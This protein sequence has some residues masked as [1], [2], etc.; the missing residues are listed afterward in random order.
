MAAHLTEYHK[1]QYYRSQIHG[2][3]SGPPVV[4]ERLPN[5]YQLLRRHTPA[6]QGSPETGRRGTFDKGSVHTAGA[7]TLEL[8]KFV[9]LGQDIP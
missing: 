3:C 9:A 5:R 4:L 1:Q 7:D 2:S 8:H 6:M